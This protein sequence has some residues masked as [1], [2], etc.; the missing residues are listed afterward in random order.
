MFPVRFKL[1]FYIPEDYIFH[2]NRRENLKS[3]NTYV[4]RPRIYRFPLSVIL[5]QDSRRKQ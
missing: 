3:Y 2:S 1:D 4:I 5:F